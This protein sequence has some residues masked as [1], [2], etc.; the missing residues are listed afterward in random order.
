VSDKKKN[1]SVEDITTWK[2]YLK[3]PKDITDKD[4]KFSRDNL[5]NNRFTFDLHGFS[6]NDANTKVKEIILLCVKNNY[7]EILFITG[8]GIHSNTEK[9]IYVSK[10]LSKLKFSVPDFINSNSEISQYVNSISSAAEHEGGEGAI[11]V[12]LNKLQNKF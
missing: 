8:K 11:I 1:I 10:E 9:N 2:N 7:K 5:K 3:N 4:A 6:L 12:S